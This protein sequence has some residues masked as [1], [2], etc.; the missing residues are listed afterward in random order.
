[1]LQLNT[2]LYSVPVSAHAELVPLY[3]YTEP[4]A[5]TTTHPSSL[6]LLSPSPLP[7]FVLVSILANNSPSST[8]QG[9]RVFVY[10]DGDAV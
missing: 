7:P 3:M 2:H 8:I 6:F 10:C 9:H 4:A 1:M 5:I